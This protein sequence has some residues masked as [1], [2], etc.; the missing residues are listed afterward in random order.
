MK[1]LLIEDEAAIA[2]VIRR[3]L[4]QAHYMVET[5]QDGLIGMEM[6][7]KGNHALIILDLMLPG[8][9]GWRI[10]ADLRARRHRTP[11]LILTARGA[12]ADRVRGLDIGADDYLPK[13][14]DFA[15]LLARVQALLRRDKIH[16]SRLIR[17]EDLEIDTGLRQV[18]R[19]DREI[20][21]SHR[22]YTLLEALASREGQ[23]LSREV[24]QERVWLGEESYSNTVDVYIGL[25]RKKID[26]DHPVKLIRTVRGLGYM[27]RRPTTEELP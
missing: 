14:F 12:V 9:D 27:L 19:A 13:P 17:I 23:V 4:E 11:I 8:M 1:I 2:K 21:L 7:L 25:L 24:I 22:E 15:E 16:K 20:V 3:G 18:V 6:A 10:C 5:A 26:A